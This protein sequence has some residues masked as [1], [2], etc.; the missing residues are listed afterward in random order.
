MK[1]RRPDLTGPAIGDWRM[2]RKKVRFRQRHS[3][4]SAPSPSTSRWRSG[5][6]V[7]D[8]NCRILPYNAGTVYPRGTEIMASHVPPDWIA[9]KRRVDLMHSSKPRLGGEDPSNMKIVVVISTRAACR[10]QCW[11]RRPE[12]LTER[13][14]ETK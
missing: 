14:L 5:P 13:R 8:T 12:K 1:A 10:L 4:R 9:P 7:S 6:S 2:L 3:W 11:A